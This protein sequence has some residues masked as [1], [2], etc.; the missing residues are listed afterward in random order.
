[1]T[2]EDLTPEEIKS[3]LRDK[4]EQSLDLVGMLVATDPMIAVLLHVEHALLH[5]EKDNE[6]PD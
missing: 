3:L 4:L 1:M 6:R 5:L 2:E